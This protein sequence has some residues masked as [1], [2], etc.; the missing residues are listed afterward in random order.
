MPFR[1]NLERE[2]TLLGHWRWGHTVKK[3][4]F[5]T[6]VPEGS[7]SHYYARFNKDKDKYLRIAETKCQEPPRTSPEEAALGA[8]G[9]ANVSKNVMKLV[10]KG[11]FAKARDYLEVILLVQDLWKRMSPTFLNYDPSKWD[12]VLKN[13][14]EL[15]KLLEEAPSL[16][17]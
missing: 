4:S 11:E 6:G 15:T 8:L 16:E 10:T 12:E 2:I 1:K 14:L 3:A 9:F 17:I 13:I 7:I 5:L